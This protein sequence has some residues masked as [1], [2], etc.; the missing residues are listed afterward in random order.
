M[1]DVT[2]GGG[3]LQESNLHNIY[4]LSA[5]LSQIFC[6]RAAFLLSYV[7]FALPVIFPVFRDLPMRRHY[8]NTRPEIFLV[9]TP[10]KMTA[11]SPYSERDTFS[12][13]S[14]SKQASADKEHTVRTVSK[15]IFLKILNFSCFRDLP[16][17]GYFLKRIF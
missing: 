5:V 1:C 11:F 14:S 13:Q 12:P 4:M 16:I 6:G 10:L 2:S 3:G 15:N 17:E 8:R 7:S 9:T